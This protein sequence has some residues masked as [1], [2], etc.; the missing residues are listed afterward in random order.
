MSKM[1]AANGVDFWPLDDVMVGIAT[2]VPVKGTV[3]V[4]VLVLVNVSLTI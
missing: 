2:A 1:K 4:A 3:A